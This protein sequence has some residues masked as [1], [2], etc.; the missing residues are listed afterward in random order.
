MSRS[1]LQGDPNVK[2]ITAHIVKK[3]ADKLS[4]IFKNDRAGFEEKW[5][6]LSVFVKYGVI[7]DEKFAERAKR[8]CFGR[9]YR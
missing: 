3:V 9:K 7:S 6:S 4:E 2:K 1:Y 8:I 5:E